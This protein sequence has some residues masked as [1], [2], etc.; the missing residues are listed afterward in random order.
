MTAFHTDQL[1]LKDVLL[2][3]LSVS[4]QVARHHVKGVQHI[5]AGRSMALARAKQQILP[6]QNS[7]QLNVMRASLV[8]LGLNHVDP[9]AL[10][11]ICRNSCMGLSQYHSAPSTHILSIVAARGQAM[12]NV[13]CFWETAEMCQRSNRSGHG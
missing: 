9:A 1:A 7:P 11:H 4:S 12:T 8:S 5:Q 2:D 13:I 10:R 3:V 6:T